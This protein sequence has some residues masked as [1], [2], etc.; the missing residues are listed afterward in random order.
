MKKLTI[1]AMLTACLVQTLALERG[2][3]R[4]IRATA[5]REWTGTNSLVTLSSSTRTN[6]M[7]K[8]DFVLGASYD[9]AF[10]TD[11]K[12]PDISTNVISHQSTDPWL[13]IDVPRSRTRLYTTWVRSVNGALVSD[14]TQGP[15]IF[16]P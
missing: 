13:R 3:A 6:M 4:L 14:W 15:R 10:T 9:I 16:N 5:K 12:R 11:G 2:A 8:W 1:I 7:L